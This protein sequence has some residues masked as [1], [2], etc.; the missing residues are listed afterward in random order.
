MLARGSHGGFWGSSPGSGSTRTPHP[1]SPGLMELPGLWLQAACSNSI[2]GKRAS[3]PLLRIAEDP[4]S[5]YPEKGPL[6]PA[7]GIT[8]LDGVAQA[9]ATW[10]L[11]PEWRGLNPEPCWPCL[12]VG[13]PCPVASHW[14]VARPVGWG[15]RQH[16]DP[17]PACVLWVWPVVLA[18]PVPS[19]AVEICPA[20][21]SPH[22]LCLCLVSRCSLTRK[23]PLT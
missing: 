1:C 20:S 19:L 11:F 9:P 8:L 10:H 17:R 7:P 21:S 13:A 15:T 22:S 3:A 12:L 16:A 23:A 18:G 6:M 2:M 5:W 14:E 4:G